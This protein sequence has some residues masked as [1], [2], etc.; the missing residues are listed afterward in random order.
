MEISQIEVSV[1]EVKERLSD[2]DTT[3][4]CGP[5]EIP[6]RLLMECSE[7]IAPSLCSLFIY[8][9]NKGKIS[10]EWKSADVTPIHKKKILK[11]L[12]KIIALYLYSPLSVKFWNAV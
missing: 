3:K 5:D 8:S 7:Q 1:N 11:R 12:R 10:R 9:L 6:A 2:L 4:A